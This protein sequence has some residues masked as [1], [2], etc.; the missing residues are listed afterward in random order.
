MPTNLDAMGKLIFILYLKREI[1][2]IFQSYF[3]YQYIQ[4]FIYAIFLSQYPNCIYI[5]LY[6]TIIILSISKLP[7]LQAL[8]SEK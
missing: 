2:F 5:L 7:F 1:S 6:N 8:K 4:N 3:I